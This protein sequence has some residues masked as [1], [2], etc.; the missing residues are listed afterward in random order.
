MTVTPGPGKRRV[1]VVDD[2]R[3]SR[4]L[5]RRTLEESGYEV[6]QAGDGREALAELDARPA[7]I[8]VTDWQMPEMDGIELCREL[9]KRRNPTYVYILFLTA[10]SGREDLLAAMQAGADEFLTKPLD[11]LELRARLATAERVLGLETALATR[12]A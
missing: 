8:V 10:R 1:L 3:A 5:L 11:R 4:L 9:R 6:A 7:D 12:V 2:D